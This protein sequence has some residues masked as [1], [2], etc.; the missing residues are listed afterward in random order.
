MLYTVFSFAQSI[1]SLIHNIIERMFNSIFHKM[2]L[3]TKDK[4]CISH[5]L[6]LLSKHTSILFHIKRRSFSLRRKNAFSLI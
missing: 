4:V 3:L 5:L 2:Y 1:L 6:L